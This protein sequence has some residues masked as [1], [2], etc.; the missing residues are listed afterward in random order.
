MS[1]N[2]SVVA[3]PGPADQTQGLTVAVG[4]ADGPGPALFGN[5]GV[6]LGPTL[7]AERQSLT[8]DQ[9][10]PLD[11]TVGRRS[12]VRIARGLSEPLGFQIPRR[13]RY[14]SVAD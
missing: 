6:A 5:S 4:T 8:L 14:L 10:Q 9:S 11:S 3:V 13:C 7:A 2:E 1:P 12:A